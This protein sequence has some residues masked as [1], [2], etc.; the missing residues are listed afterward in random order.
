MKN[1]VSTV[2]SK[3]RCPECAKQNKDIS[4]DNLAIYSDGHSY[5]FSCGYYSS[6]SLESKLSPQKQIKRGY[7]IIDP[8]PEDITKTFR[9]DAY[10]WITK[11]LDSKDIPNTLF[12][13]EQK[14][15]LI[16]PYFDSNNTLIAWQ[17]RYFGSNS[18]H[19]KWISYGKIH[20]LLNILPLN[21]TKITNLVL[22][23]DILSAI[24]VSKVTTVM[25]I[26]WSVIPPS[27]LTRLRTL[28]Y[29]NISIWLDPDKRKESI[30]FKQQAE[31]YGLTAN[32]IFSDKDP[33][34][35]SIEQIEKI[36]N[37]KN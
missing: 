6:P 19:P 30:F 5:C 36:L 14:E 12:W 26:F 21:S 11:Y 37:E 7:S 20:D 29:N 1:N 31:T 2:I 27:L 8:L 23:E 10:A 24:K 28:G 16:F 3:T 35:Y 9:K 33:K 22:V 25:P 34:E 17:A 4:G 15:Y 18:L 32:I 13:S